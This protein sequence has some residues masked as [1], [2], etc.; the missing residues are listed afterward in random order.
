MALYNFSHI[1]S[2]ITALTALSRKTV[3]QTGCKTFFCLFKLVAA[4]SDC[5]GL[6]PKNRC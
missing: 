5:L 6:E 3:R 2:A 4:L 1:L